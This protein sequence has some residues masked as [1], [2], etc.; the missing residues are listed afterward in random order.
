M[1][2]VTR[3]TD[4]G[5]RAAILADQVVHDLPFADVAEVLAA[6]A[7]APGGL[8]EVAAQAGETQAVEAVSLAPVI[9]AP[10]KIFC[11]G[12]NYTGHIA[13][14]GR[15]TPTHPT[16]FAKFPIA[17]VGPR[18]PIVLPKESQSVDWEAELALVI[19]QQVRHA[20]EDEARAAIAGYTIMNDISM[21]D[22]QLRTQQ[23]LAGKTFERS[24]PLGPALVTLDELADPDDLAISCSVDGVTMQE[25][26][27]SDL[28]FDP[29]S[30]VR[31]IS[32]IC[33][34]VPGDVIATG[35]PSGIGNTRN[36]KVFLQ[37]GQS[38]VTEIEG[39]GQLVNRCESDGR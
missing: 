36:P 26:R 2:L 29:V 39:L 10:S 11:V 15:D 13:E 25:S 34:L 17:L 32:T 31:F 21:R 9:P 1:R 22:W 23:W 5:T 33:T 38:L 4:V 27:T 35:T 24:T 12:L 20:T 19:G 37:D 7:T 3:R 16:L 8:A 28:L 18:D 14:T 30:L 6:A